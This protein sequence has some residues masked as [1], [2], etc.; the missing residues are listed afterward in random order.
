MKNKQW[1]YLL[2]SAYLL[3]P[4]SAIATPLAMTAATISQAEAPKVSPQSLAASSLALQNVMHMQTQLQQ[5]KMQASV[6][7][8]KLNILHI[9]E[10]I[11]K[12]SDKVSQAGFGGP[13]GKLRILS[14]GCFMQKCTATASQGH[15]QF[16][17]HPGEH[18]NNYYFQKITAGGVLVTHNGVTRWL[19]IDGNLTKNIN[20][21]GELTPRGTQLP[22][23]GSIP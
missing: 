19:G 7:K 16:I 10:Q 1:L 3:I 9:D 22:P 12:T 6:L 14:S 13:T 2:S 15:S 4:A 5:M 18:L 21:P 17:I 23:V 20:G 8:E 11:A